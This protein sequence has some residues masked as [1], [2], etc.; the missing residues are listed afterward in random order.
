M[1]QKLLLIFGLCGSTNEKAK[2]ILEK[3]QLATTYMS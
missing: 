2:L 1:S 3:T